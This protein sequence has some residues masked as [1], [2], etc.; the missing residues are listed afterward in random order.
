MCTQHCISVLVLLAL[1]VNAALQTVSTHTLV[2]LMTVLLLL[3]VAVKCTADYAAVVTVACCSVV[4]FSIASD[5]D[6]SLRS[7]AQRSYL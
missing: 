6:R 1:S 2:V 4:H 7:F 5:A 3:L